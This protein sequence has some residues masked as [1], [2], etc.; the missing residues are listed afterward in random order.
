M[1]DADESSFEEEITLFINSCKATSLL[2]S[3]SKKEWKHY[4]NILLNK[5]P[6]EPS[7]LSFLFYSL[8]LPFCSSGRRDLLIDYV[9]WMGE[10]GFIKRIRTSDGFIHHLCSSFHYLFLLIRLS[11]TFVIVHVWDCCE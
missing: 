11:F 5:C 4:L 10:I 1:L 2:E 9:R 6:N 3:I 8:L 7:Y